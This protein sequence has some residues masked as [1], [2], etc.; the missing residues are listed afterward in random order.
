[1]RW[2][3]LPTI[4][5][6]HASLTRLNASVGQPNRQRRRSAVTECFQ[7]SAI[8]HRELNHVAAIA[9]SSN[10][11]RNPSRDVPGLDNINNRGDLV[12]LLVPKQILFVACGDMIF[13]RQRLLPKFASRSSTA[14][15]S[16]QWLSRP[17]S[18]LPLETGSYMRVDVNAPG[19]ADRKTDDV[20]R[21]SIATATGC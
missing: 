20:R 21:V 14:K 19:N 8:S 6:N 3:R 4:S 16:K 2:F 17:S 9:A 7:T 1:M 10:Q 18:L 15:T 13:I 11:P 5:S 12:T